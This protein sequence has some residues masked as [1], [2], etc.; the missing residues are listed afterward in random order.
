MSEDTILFRFR[1]VE[2]DLDGQPHT[3]VPLLC[4]ESGGRLSGSEMVQRASQIPGD[5]GK[6]EARLFARHLHTIPEPLLAEIDVIFP[7]WRHVHSAADR[8]D[9][10]GGYWMWAMR[11]C[12]TLKGPMERLCHS[13]DRR[14]TNPDGRIPCI[15]A[16]GRVPKKIS[17][18]PSF[19]RQVLWRPIGR[20]SAYP[21]PKRAARARR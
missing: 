9:V 13:H 20:G 16:R 6:E 21:L 15:L 18:P 3:L 1:P 11:Y 5:A 8:A 10:N 14:W 19:Q 12:D 2:I 7:D 17:P 4:P